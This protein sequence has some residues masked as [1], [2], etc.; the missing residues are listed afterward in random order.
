MEYIH[1][2]D[3]NTDEK[4]KPSLDSEVT[5]QNAAPASPDCIPAPGTD[6]QQDQ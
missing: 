6:H 5:G 4:E 1:P 2:Y 3:E